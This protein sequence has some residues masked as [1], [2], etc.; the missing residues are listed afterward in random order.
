MLFLPLQQSDFTLQPPMVTAESSVRTQHP[1][2]GNQYRNRI[3]AAVG[4]A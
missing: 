3:L 4:T 1:V 2:T